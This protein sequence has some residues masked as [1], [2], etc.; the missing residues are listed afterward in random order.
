MKITIWINSNDV[1]LIYGFLKGKYHKF[2]KPYSI[3]ANE[4]K[5]GLQVMIDF[6]DY[7]K[8]IEQ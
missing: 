7:L 4:I 6:E 5:D 2:D 1:H 3:V 8:L